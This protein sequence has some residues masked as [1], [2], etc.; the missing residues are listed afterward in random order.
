MLLPSHYS[1]HKVQVQVQVQPLQRA[2]FAI[3]HAPSDDDE[4]PL[5]IGDVQSNSDDPWKTELLTRLDRVQSKCGDLCKINSEEPGNYARVVDN[6]KGNFPSYKVNID[7]NAILEMDEL[8]VGDTSVPYP[9][10]EELHQFY[11]MGGAVNVTMWK[12]FTD[13][14]LGGEARSSTWTR[15]YIEKQLGLLKSFN[16]AE[17]YAGVSKRMVEKLSAWVDLGGKSVLVIGS[18]KP[19]LEI[20]CLFLGA[21]KVTTLEYGKITSE[22]P[23][24]QTLLPHEFRA[25]AR[26]GTLGLFDGILTHSSLEH[27]GLGRYGDALNPWGDLLNVARGHCVTKDDGFMVLG[28]PTGRDQVAFNAH[29]I[30]G[31]FRL[32]LVSSN[33]VQIDGEDHNAFEFTRDSGN[34]EGGGEI[35]VFLKSTEENH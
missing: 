2:S 23:Q 9:L 16:A 24:I 17:T 35:F 13:I 31:Y 4:Q 8:D 3:A 32:P 34:Y 33:W 29:R 14:Y 22:H 5:Q 21:S 7:C 12:K 15:D 11:S 10:P 1:P 27:S 25:K 26:D 6:P 18:E 19:W 28:V 20:I 30:Y